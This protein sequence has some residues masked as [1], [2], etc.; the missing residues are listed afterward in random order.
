MSDVPKCIHYG[1]CRYCCECQEDEPWYTCKH[2]EVES[3]EEEPVS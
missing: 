3:K 2:R 1:D